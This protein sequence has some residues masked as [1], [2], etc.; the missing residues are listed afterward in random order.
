VIMSI[1]N[2]LISSPIGN[3][4]LECGFQGITAL[5]FIDTGNI[6]Q[7]LIPD[8]FHLVFEL[9]DKKEPP[10]DIISALSWLNS[11]SRGAPPESLDFLDLSIAGTSVFSKKVFACLLDVKF[12]NTITYGELA[13]KAGNPRAARAIGQ[14][15]ASNP[16]PLFVPCH[17]VLSSSGLGG[18]TPGIAIKK[19][20][21]E[22]ETLMLK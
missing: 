16:L 9:S 22:H 4:S 20:L 19:L 8:R 14:I 3:L 7:F 1:S 21:L 18:Y 12:G 5:K 2:W 11:Y 15:M 10:D 17:R 13:C 6:A